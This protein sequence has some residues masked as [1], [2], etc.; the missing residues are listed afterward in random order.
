VTAGST[1]TVSITLQ[2][3]SKGGGG[4]PG[5]GM[6]GYPAEAIAVGIVFAVAVLLFEKRRP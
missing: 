6:L 1:A 3:Q 2:T 5:G 4:T